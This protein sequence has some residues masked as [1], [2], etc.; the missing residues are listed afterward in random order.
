MGRHILPNVVRPDPRQH[1]A[2][3]ADRDPLRDDARRSSGSATRRAPSWGKM[4]EE[5][6]DA[7]R[8]DRAGVVV[9]RAAGR[10]RSCSSC[11]RSRSCGHALEEIL[12][13]RLRERLVVSA[14]PAA[15]RRAA[16]RCCRCATCTSTYRT[17]AGPLPAVRGVDLDLAAGRDARARG[18][19]GLRQVDARR[20]RCCGCC[21]S[22]TEVSGEVLLDGEDVLAMKP[23]PAARGA[24]DRHGDR[25]PGRAAHAQPRAADRPPDRRGD[26]AAPKATRCGPT[27]ARRSASCSSSSGC[28]RAAPPTTRTSSRAASASAC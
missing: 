28:R 11:S 22:G 19:V 17:G 1:D 16:R 5:A 10:R 18:R 26:R 20:A 6:F 14:E 12:D 4:L 25:L 27:D 8:A 3:G 9:L 7:G 2:D 15:R 23:G 24:L 13:P 21:R